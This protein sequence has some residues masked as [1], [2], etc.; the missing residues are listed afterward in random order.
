ME[1]AFDGDTR[2]KAI[3][4]GIKGGRRRGNTFELSPE[5]SLEELSRLAETAGYE[6]CGT[7]LQDRRGPDPATYLGKGKVQELAEEAQRCEAS[8]IIVDG[9]LSASTARNLCEITKT[10]TLDRKELILNIFA[11]RAVTREGKIQVELAA[12]QHELSR[13]AGY[14]VSMSNPGGGIGTRGPGEQKIETERR[15]LRARI[16]RLTKDLK[17]AEKVRAQGR[18]TREDSGIPLV[19]LV[20]YTNAGKSSLFNVLTGDSALCDDK[21]FA[22]LDPWVRRWTLES[23]ETLFL[24]DTVGFIQGL[25]HELVA[26]FRATLE[27][28]LNADLLVHVIDISSPAW[29]EQMATTERVLEELGAGDTPRI[30]CFNKCDLVAEKE[31]LELAKDLYQ[32][33]VCTSV[34]KG[35]GLG[36]L[37]V[38]IGR[39]LSRDRQTVTLSIPYESWGILS[40][41]R[42]VGSILH[43][44]HLP[45]G[46]HVRCRLSPEDVGKYKELLRT[47]V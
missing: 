35:E 18:K 8:V 22:T 44:E 28:S 29:R 12:R 13:L 14:G 9:S 3:L 10:Q 46:A 40:E 36:E 38:A 23:G 15:L 6:V 34:L 24:C 20:G 25:P 31:L 33:A 26:A 17:K 1:R 19:S 39:E 21:L 43:L 11:S 45:E 27:E 32:P 7:M 16:A 47:Q 41:I 5:D 2:Q 30:H 42:Q 4:V 37:R